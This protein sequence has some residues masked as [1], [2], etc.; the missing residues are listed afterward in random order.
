MDSRVIYLQ[1]LNTII[2]SLTDSRAVNMS[3]HPYRLQSIEDEKRLLEKMITLQ[4]KVRQTKEK[5]RQLKST[6]NNHYSRIFQPITNSLKQLNPSKPT[7]VVK[8]DASTSTDKLS[9]D[10]Y[11]S[12]DEQNTDDETDDDEKAIKDD[13][14]D[15]YIDALNSIPLRCRDDGIFGLNDETKRIGIY[16]YIVDGDTLRVM[17]NGEQI[18]SFVIDDYEL[19]QLLLVKRPNDIKLK[20]RDIRG[21]NTH[22]LDE[23]IR[24]VQELDLVAIAERSGVQIKNRAKY[25]LLPKVGHGFLFTST[26]PKFLK[27]N[28]VHPSVVVIPSDKKGLLRELIKSVAELRSGN[29]S[30]Q[31]VVVPLAKEAQRL[32]ILPPGLLSPKEM[33]WVYA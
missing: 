20:M 11:K 25:K 28:L 31:N 19:W 15:L 21:K 4:G 32:K 16:S 22:A 5:E 1:E 26:K 33:T 30:M 6:Q 14:D 12:A 8:F 13:P 9:D 17:D 24:I 23:F 7:P 27:N 29:T 3:Y 2:H 10:S 18:R